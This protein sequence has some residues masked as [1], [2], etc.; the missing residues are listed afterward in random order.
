MLQPVPVTGLTMKTSPILAQLRGLYPPASHSGSV[1][2]CL[3]CFGYAHS[4]CLPRPGPTCLP[5][6]SILNGLNRYRRALHTEHQGSLARV[7]DPAPLEDVSAFTQGN[8]LPWNPAKHSSV[9]QVLNTASSL[10][11]KVTGSKARIVKD[12]QEEMRV[13][14]NVYDTC[15]TL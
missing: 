10:A 6:Y 11:Q 8:A 2:E 4:L 1:R 3:C 5:R 12:T 7:S 9:V 13:S 15:Q 14:M